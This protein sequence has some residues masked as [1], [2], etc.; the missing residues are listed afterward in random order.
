MKPGATLE[1][2]IYVADGNSVLIYPERGHNRSPVGKITDGISSAYGLWIDSSGDLY[3]ANSGSDRVV[4]YHRGS[5]TPF[6]TYSAGLS[7]PLY[8]VVNSAGDLWVGNANNGR[9]VEY[10]HGRTTIERTLQTEG[11]EV[12]GMDFDTQGNLYAAYRGGG[13]TPSIEEF[14]YNAWGGT[15]LGMTLNAPQSV[16]VTKGGTILAV[17][18]QGTDRIDVFPPGDTIPTLEV[19]VKNI[20]TQLAITS[21]EQNLYVSSLNTGDIWV[22]PYP[23]LN[24]NGSPNVLH[25]KF[26]VGGDYVVQGIALNDG[27]TF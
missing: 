15:V 23:L 18:T 7:R 14:S 20:P 1:R 8:P 11:S 12:D 6:R 9:I 27:Q 4:A 17:E 3:V 24:P 25:E 21:S 19:G 16:I 26:Q 10:R 2:L 13:H 22:S 5:T